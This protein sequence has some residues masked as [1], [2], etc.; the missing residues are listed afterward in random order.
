MWFCFLATR[1]VAS[2]ALFAERDFHMRRI[3]LV[4]IVLTACFGSPLISHAQFGG[5]GGGG[6]NAGGGG[7]FGGGGGGGGLGGGGGGMGGGGLGGGLGG[8]MGGTG[9]LGGGLGAGLSGAMGGQTGANGMNG[10]NNQNGQGFLGRN[11]NG[12]Q[13]FLGRNTQAQ[14]QNGMMTNQ[15]GGANNR[16]AGGNRGANGQNN[17]NNQQQQQGLG[18]GGGAAKQGPQIRPRQRIA[19]EHTPPHLPTVTSGLELRLNKMKALKSPSIKLST[20]PAG[21]LVLKG[22][23][24]SESAAKLAEN[25]ARLEPGVRSVKNELTYPEPVSTN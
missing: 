15:M 24:A 9:G 16:R 7:G 6:G 21:V 25:I 19:F 10:M 1:P 3:T 12:Q 18:V 13:Q 8:G 23:V 11:T 22:E 14:G 20:E 17:F 2:S 5:G 4:I